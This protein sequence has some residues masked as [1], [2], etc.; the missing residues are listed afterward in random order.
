MV[1][2]FNKNKIK[3]NKKEKSSQCHSV[4]VSPIVCFGSFFASIYL[5]DNLMILCHS[6]HEFH[7]VGLAIDHPYFNV[8]KCS[9]N[10]FRFLLF[11]YKAMP[12]S[13]PL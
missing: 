6:I 12:F 11:C 1:S 2:F 7:S 5:S 10:R 9:Y 8:V 13:S 3:H 4:V